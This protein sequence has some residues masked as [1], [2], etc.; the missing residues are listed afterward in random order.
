MFQSLKKCLIF[1]LFQMAFVYAHSL[2]S[3]QLLYAKSADSLKD[4][5][6]VIILFR[7]FPTL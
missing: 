1:T 2:F 7:N 5:V 3:V 4:E 6:E